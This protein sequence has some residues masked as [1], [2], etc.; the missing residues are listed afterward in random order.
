MKISIDR[1]TCD[2]WQGACESCFGWRLLKLMEEGELHPATCH[3][4]AQ[5]DGQLGF[6]F[7]IHDKDQQDKILRIDKDNWHKAYE[8]WP[9]LLEKQIADES[10][11]V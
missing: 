6:T 9:E 11:D 7:L 2:C 3:V 10:S 5:E 4:E 8:A 1:T